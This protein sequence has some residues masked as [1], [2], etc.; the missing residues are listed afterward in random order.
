[1][2][3][4][5]AEAEQIR[6]DIAAQQ[7]DATK[8]VNELLDNLEERRTAAKQEAN[9]LIGKAK[10]TREEADAYA[11]QK[12]KAADEQAA[13][14]LQ[15]AQEDAAKQIE[16]RRQAAKSE[17]DGLQQHI[18]ELQQRE[19][20]ITQRVTE[21]RSMFA[22]AFSG[23]NFGAPKAETDDVAVTGVVADGEGAKPKA[24][25]Q[26]Q[27]LPASQQAQLPASSANEDGNA[28]N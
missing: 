16:E 5:D 19:S 28:N 13:Q 11:E 3:Q 10:K 21:L 23:F 12:R 22:N 4:V 20:S 14:I 6:A 1:M 7:D 26:D 15:K 27:Q 24:A 9:D 25:A 17:L 8:K 18:A 2:S